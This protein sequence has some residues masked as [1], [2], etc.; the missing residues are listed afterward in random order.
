M[1]RHLAVQTSLIALLAM[2]PSGAG[3]QTASPTEATPAADTG[4]GAAPRPVDAT[5][6]T[7]DA[8]DIVVTATRRETTL[9]KTPIAISVFSQTQLDR[10]QVVNPTDLQRF[11]PS[12]QFNQQAD[13]N[14]IL[15]TL[16]GIGNDSAFTDSADPEVGVYVDGIYSPTPQGGTALL[17]DL[18]RVEVLR[19]P[20]GTLFGRNTTAG[21]LQLITAKP[22]T[23]A[24]SANAELIGGGYNRIGARGMMNLPVTD[25]LAL[26]FAFATEQRDG[27]VRYQQPPATLPGL[28]K[29][30]YI[31]SGKRYGAQDQRSARVALMWAPSDRFRWDINLEGYLDRGSPD[32]SLMQTPRPG[33]KLYSAL[34]DSA[35]DSHRYAIGVRSTM[36]YLS[37]D[38]LGLTYIAGFN[39]V[40]GTSQSDADLGVLPPLQP[41]GSLTPYASEQDRT[42]YKRA[43][44]ISQELQLKSRGSHRIDWILGGFF[45]HE[46]NAARFDIDDRDGNRSGP[47]S[48]SVSFLAP[49]YQV[50]SYAGFGQATFNANDRLHLTGGLRYSIDRKTNVDAGALYLFGCPT[51]PTPGAPPCRGIE[52]QFPGTSGPELAGLLGPD[53]TY[54]P[55]EGKGTFRKLTYL[56]RADY[57]LT[58]TAL[59]YGSI[60]TGFK[61]GIIDALNRVTGPETLTD[62]E[63]GAKTKLF[64]RKL[65]LNLAA[66][67]YDFEG[68]QIG[69][70]E[71]VRD[72]QGNIISSTLQTLNAED[73]T[74]YGF[75]T[76]AVWD[77]TPDDHI[78]FSAALQNTRL[79][80][81]LTI[82]QRFDG[83]P[84]DAA[85]VRELAG[86][87]LP[88][89][90]RFA[91]T[92]TYEHDFALPNGGR[93]TPRGTVHYETSSY[94]TIFNGDRPTPI[95]DGQPGGYGRAF[96]RQKAYS[97]SDLALRYT[98]GD[99]RYVVEAFVQN[100]ENRA[101]RTSATT[102]GLA[103]DRNSFLS[104]LQPP[105]TFGGRVKVSF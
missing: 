100:L 98:P 23:D 36:D 9:Q 58:D 55:S 49:R 41:D 44:F 80:S 73:A 89:A 76:E 13:N 50:D 43:D 12:L 54:V 63:L 5:Q 11:V 84:T 86:N 15:I 27:Y 52:G 35:P 65:T 101:V 77:V 14:A 1:N 38:D 32:A 92:L 40:G 83:D 105:R 74:N 94:L 87:Q 39:R 103:T 81:L 22:R 91:A 96:D 20:Q 30:A 26:R 72:A 61:S 78:Q 104:L 37:N 34:I 42:I 2:V 10:Q 3:A 62:Y 24:V 82:D 45:S 25:T 16:R 48:F 56:A 97:R 88:H 67:Y 53:F 21:A 66:Y 47:S 17:Y 90:P 8:G 4:Q 68:Y 28:D 71:V 51:P 60:S 46:N 29:S 18:E 64:D 19:G 57:N 33:E 79:K 70:I 6:G 59:L 99:K 93:I 102:Y 85:A 69:Q 31:T 7:A 95:V 75:E